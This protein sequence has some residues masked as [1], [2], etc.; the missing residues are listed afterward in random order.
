MYT[1][2]V[3]GDLAPSGLFS[4]SGSEAVVVC[5]DGIAIAPSRGARTFRVPASATPGA[6]IAIAS[7]RGSRRLEVADTGPV[8]WVILL[9]GQS[10]MVSRADADGCEPWPERVRFVTQ[11]GRLVAAAPQIASAAGDAG[12]FLIA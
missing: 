5:V 11:A 3:T 4:V 12:P 9:A 8:T 6:P 2:A 7:D 1:L 10:N